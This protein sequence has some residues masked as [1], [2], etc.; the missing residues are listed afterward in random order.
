MIDFYP[1]HLAKADRRNWPKYSDN[2]LSRWLKQSLINFW[3]ELMAVFCPKSSRGSC[4]SINSQNIHS[5]RKLSEPT[6]EATI[7]ARLSQQVSKLMSTCLILKIRDVC[8]YKVT[9]S[10]REVPLPFVSSKCSFLYRLAIN[11][12]ESVNFI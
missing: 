1:Y 3:T 8:L 9:T 12:T 7:G 4:N 2:E 5:D 10:S 11:G 6:V